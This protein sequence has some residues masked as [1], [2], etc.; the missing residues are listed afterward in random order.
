MV[1][2]ASV[3][4]A[5]RVRCRASCA[6]AAGSLPPSVAARRPVCS[7][8]PAPQVPRQR[9]SKQRNRMEKEVMKRIKSLQRR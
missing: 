6:A 7:A 5:V 2:V 8:T 1:L 4:A 9:E 3:P